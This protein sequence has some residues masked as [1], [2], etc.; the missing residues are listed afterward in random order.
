M[1]PES[2]ARSSMR[3]L[4][5]DPKA[6]NPNVKRQHRHLSITDIVTVSTASTRCLQAR[7]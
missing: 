5:E 2:P 6:R 1:T 3:K 4:K 7:C